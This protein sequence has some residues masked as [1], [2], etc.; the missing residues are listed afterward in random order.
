MGNYPLGPNTNRLE[1]RRLGSQLATVEDEK[2]HRVLE[3]VDSLGLRGEAD[4]VIAPVRARLARL[5]PKRRLNFNRL[6]FTPFNPL[7]VDTANWTPGCITIPRTA[8]AALARQVHAGL[9][10]ECSAPGPLSEAY[11]CSDDLVSILDAGRKVWPAAAEVLRR[12]TAA[13]P[14]WRDETGLRDQDFT[15]L[16]IALQILLP[17]TAPLI[18]IALDAMDGSNSEREQLL[19][20]LDAVSQAGARVTAMFIAMALHW[21]PC[22]EM[23]IKVA[24]QFVGGQASPAMA[25][26]IDTAVE[27][28]L[29][30]IE[31]SSASGANLAS[32]ASE[33]RHVAVLLEDL[34]T[35]SANKPNRR[36]RIEQVRR[37]VDE[38]CRKSFGQK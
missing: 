3:L 15:A 14:E 8:L 10:A 18:Q 4:A 5:R 9:L 13:P 31:Q 6:L 26:T 7:V 1:G 20:M 25:T 19:E 22:T 21:L 23:F 36:S 33:I 27:V 30:G 12:S 37:N 35:C 11:R 34:A 29:S 16:R 24:D 17:Q 38:A 32:A 28:V 2:I